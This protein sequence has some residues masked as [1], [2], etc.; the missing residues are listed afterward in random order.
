M[1]PIIRWTLRERRWTVLWWIVGIGAYIALN[2]LVYGTVRANAEQLN[3]ALQQLPATMK[4]LLGGS[5]D[6][7]SPIGYLNSKLY[8]MFIPL[9]FSFLSIS[10]GSSLLAREEQQRT[11][12]L[13][14]ARPI[15]RGKLLLA[16]AMAGLGIILFIGLS[17]LLIT[18][19][20]AKA[21]GLDTS[22]ANIAHV[23]MLSLLYSII[24]G[25]FAFMLAAMG[26]GARSASFG[27]AASLALAGYIINS[28]KDTASWLEWVSRAL[29]YHY[30]R[31]AEILRGQQ[32]TAEAIG[33]I[34]LMLI[35]GAI[36]WLAFRRRDIE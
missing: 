30:Y 32:A 34:V 16:K 9:L 10:L 14:L 19:A 2:L 28:L 22:L 6:F 15:S 24:F 4:S 29:P 13:L 3:Q 17:T 7:V 21:G 23:H 35:F 27:L 36:A 18:L 25:S 31:P 1:I 5:N 12:E 20:C 33:F 11:I 8:Y 26:Y